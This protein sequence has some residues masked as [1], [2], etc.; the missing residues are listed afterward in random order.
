MGNAGYGNHTETG[1]DPKRPRPSE[2]P[3]RRKPEPGG[4]EDVAP[5]GPHDD[6]SLVN[7]DST[8]G[9]GTLPPPSPQ[10]DIDSTSG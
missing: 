2:E 5:A 3:S 4:K 9:A 8:P 6:P 10:S 1:G 7:R